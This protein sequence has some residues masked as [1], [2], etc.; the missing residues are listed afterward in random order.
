MPDYT[1]LKRLLNGP[2]TAVD[3]VKPKNDFEVGIYLKLPYYIDNLINVGIM[4]VGRYELTG[5]GKSTVA[6]IITDNLDNILG[7][8]EW[9]DDLPDDIIKRNLVYNFVFVSDNHQ[10]FTTSHGV[11]R[12]SDDSILAVRNWKTEMRTYFLRNP[13]TGLFV[14]R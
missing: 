1:E 3:D 7:S 8:L 10:Y 13:P 12:R 2:Y 9:A 14:V 11:Y 4:C 6:E 5:N